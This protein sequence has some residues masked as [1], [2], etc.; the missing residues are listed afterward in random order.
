MRAELYKLNVYGPGGHF[1]AHVD[2]PRSQQMFGSL[3]VCLPSQFSGGALLTRHRGV[4]T[5]FDWSSPLEDRPAGQ[6]VLLQWAAFFSDVEHEVLPVTAGYRVTLTY[7]LYYDR[8]PASAPILTVTN[9]PFY[10]QLRTSLASPYFMRGGGVLGFTAQHEYVFVKLN[11]AN[12]LPLLLKGADRIVFLVAKSLGLSVLVKP[13]VPCHCESPIGSCVAVHV[14]VKQSSIIGLMNYSY[15][16][17][18]ENPN[19]MMMMMMINFLGYCCHHFRSFLNVTQWMTE[20]TC[21]IRF[22]TCL[23]LTSQKASPGAKFAVWQK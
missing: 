9:Y 11:R 22:G 13:V 4:E 12:D 18:V 17:Q 5:V 10:H 2:T 3:V 16:S 23:M 21:G 1:K 15:C 14:S 6:S 8:P 20:S 7:N 19:F